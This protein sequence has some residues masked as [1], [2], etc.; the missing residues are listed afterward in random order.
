MDGPPTIEDF[1]EVGFNPFTAAKELG[2]ERKL[3]A[4]SGDPTQW[5]AFGYDQAGSRFTPAALNTLRRVAMSACTILSKVSAPIH[6]GVSPCLRMAL[7]IS[8]SAMMRPISF[9]NCCTMRRGVADATKMP[10]QPL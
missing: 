6:C 5:L 10:Y 9:D 7:L 8:G 1:E 2:G 3:T 4:M